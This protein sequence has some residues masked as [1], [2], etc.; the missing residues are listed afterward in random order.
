MTFVYLQWNV[1][2]LSVAGAHFIMHLP[3]DEHLGGP[4]FWVKYNAVMNAHIEVWGRRWVELLGL[5]F[6]QCHHSGKKCI[7]YFQYLVQ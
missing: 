6:E 5:T 3:V 7:F 4:H 2:S 1:Q